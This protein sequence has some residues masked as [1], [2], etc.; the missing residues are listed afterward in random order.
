MHS[1]LIQC[2]LFCGLIDQYY[3]QMIYC[4]FHMCMVARQYVFVY[5]V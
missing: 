1:A 4:R 3:L 5:D 2:E